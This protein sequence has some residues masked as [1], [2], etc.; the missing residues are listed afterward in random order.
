LKTHLIKVHHK[1]IT[2]SIN[3]VFEN[4]LFEHMRENNSLHVTED[5]LPN[6]ENLSELNDHEL[7][8]NNEKRYEC[9]NCH[10]QFRNLYSLSWHITNNP[11]HSEN[12]SDNISENIIDAPS[13]EENIPENKN[14][15]ENQSNFSMMDSEEDIKEEP[16]QSISDDMLESLI[17]NYNNNNTNSEEEP[18]MLLKVHS[19]EI[20]A[21]SNI[22]TMEEEPE[23][24]LKVHSNGSNAY[25]NT[26][27]DDKPEML[28][29]VHSN[30]N[31]ACTNNTNI[32]EP[33]MLLKVHSDENNACTNN[34]NIEE[35]LM[36]LKMH[37]NQSNASLTVK[38]DESDNPDECEIPKI[39]DVQSH[40]RHS[41][42][43]ITKLN[44][45]MYEQKVMMCDFCK[46][47]FISKYKLRIHIMKHLGNPQH[48]CLLC[49][50]MFWSKTLLYIH[51][52]NCHSG[53]LMYQCDKCLEIFSLYS[54]LTSHKATFHDTKQQQL[55]CKHCNE[56]FTM[57]ANLLSHIRNE[58]RGKIFHCEFCYK[59][60]ITKEG[61]ICMSF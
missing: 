41:L 9:R 61:C 1:N 40:H 34:T 12:I 11:G 4:S 2:T 8:S 56:I 43:D 29:K 27:I 59:S 14:Y 42:F 24:L 31:N 25:S 47:C 54:D 44:E 49:H 45:F 52:R 55:E 19:N 26:N 22:T 3:N 16:L 51:L 20:N 30:E 13:Y 57:R 17:L 53:E 32:E 37:S 5:E 39:I 21:Y 46:D 10:K 7:E 6:V 58:H 36:L 60:F 18:E 33:E 48:A 15:M 28:L 50:K 38:T 23:M 35:L